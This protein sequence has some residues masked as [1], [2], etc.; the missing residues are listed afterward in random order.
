MLLL[1]N[2]EHRFESGFGNTK[3]DAEILAQEFKGNMIEMP[4][5]EVALKSSGVS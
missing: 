4:L 5:I 3:L 1:E 2:D